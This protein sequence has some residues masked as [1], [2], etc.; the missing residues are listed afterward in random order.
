MFPIKAHQTFALPKSTNASMPRVLL[1][2]NFEIVSGCQLRCVGCPNSVLQPKV[3]R[4]SVSDFAACLANIDVKAI[5]TFRLFLFGE[6][7]LHRELPA[8]LRQMTLQKWRAHKIEMSTNAQFA[9]WPT[10]E[11]ALATKIPTRLVVSCDGDGTPESYEALRPP[12][13]WDTFIQFL[14]RTREIRDR[15][16]PKLELMNRTI[17]QDTAEQQRWRDILEPRGWRPEFRD[18]LP[19]VDSERELTNP[20]KPGEGLCIFQQH[21]AQVYIDFDGMVVPCCAYPRAAELGSLKTHRLSE[22]RA[23]DTLRDFRTALEA[24]DASVPS[25]ATCAWGSGPTDM[26]ASNLD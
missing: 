11:E 26:S 20:T 7:L 17:C 8:L 13:R 14:E 16:H 3:Q 2:A 1:L 24:R 5:H 19:L 23:S 18:W 6:A 9:H 12:S 22:I 4:I 15:V 21:P 25:C 10:F